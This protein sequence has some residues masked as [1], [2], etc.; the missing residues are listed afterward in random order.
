MIKALV[1]ELLSYPFRRRYQ[2]D[3]AAKKVDYDAWARKGEAEGKAGGEAGKKPEEWTDGRD[4]FQRPFCFQVQESPR[5]VVLRAS[6]GSLSKEAWERIQAYF[7]AH[8]EVVVAYGD[9][10]VEESGG[11]R[12]SPWYKPDWSPDTF[13]SYFYWGSVTVLRRSWAEGACLD[14]PWREA[15]DIDPAEFGRWARKAAEAAG[16]FRK[17]CRSIGHIPAILFHAVSEEVQDVYR[18]LDAWRGEVPAGGTVAAGSDGTAVEDASAVSGGTAYRVSLIVPSK[19]HPALLRQCLDSVLRTAQCV[20]YEVVV[21]DNGSDADNQK[22]VEALLRAYPFKASLLYRPMEFHFSEMCNLGAEH[23]LE[24]AL[25]EGLKRE[26]VFFLFLN[27]DVEQACEGWLEALVQKAALPY[28]GAVGMK[29]Y[30]PGGRRIQHDGI[31]N[32]PMGPVHKLQF[33]EDVEDY[34]HGRNREDWNVLAVTGACLMCRADRFV[35]AGGFSEEL[36]VA[37]NDVDLCF[38][39]WEAGYHNVVVNRFYAYHH[40][41]VSRGADESVE[42]LDRLQKERAKLYEAHPGLKGKDPYYPAGLG[43]DCLD[44]RIRPAYVTAQNRAQAFRGKKRAVDW[45]KVRRDECLLFR[46]ERCDDGKIQGYGIVLGDDNACYERT[47]LICAADAGEEPGEAYFLPLMGQYRPDLE[48]NLPDQKNVAL[49]GF[50]VDA[51]D[52]GARDRSMDAADGSVTGGRK[53]IAS[54]TASDLPAGTYRLGLLARNRVTGL[55]LFHW[56]NRM[57]HK[58]GKE[59]PVE[60]DGRD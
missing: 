4:R 42:K 12:H 1:K 29:L 38:R 44:T 25:A 47:L 23:A 6:R 54:I 8:P 7:D 30:Y 11:R 31:T 58:K 52:A 26:S 19:D 55:V 59:R 60:R 5:L 45:T 37:F 24:R 39:L 56:S 46:V 13:T 48:E 27:D 22:Q 15:G 33:L 3:L 2:R 40:E 51:A 50:E 34:D 9:E 10:D 35:Q 17:G 16:G 21:V 14:G 41:S 53:G 36:R 18:S 28:V 43:A 49:C 32:L 57:W 20:P